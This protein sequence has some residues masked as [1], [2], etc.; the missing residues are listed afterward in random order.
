MLT[1]FPRSIRFVGREGVNQ[2]AVGLYGNPA[3]DAQTSLHGFSAG[4]C[5]RW[6]ETKVHDKGDLM[7]KTKDGFVDLKASVGK[8]YRVFPE[9]WWGHRKKAHVYFSE[10]GIP[11]EE[12]A[13][14][15]EIVGR[16]GSKIYPHGKDGTLA[17]EMNSRSHSSM[18]ASSPFLRKKTEFENGGVYLFPPERIHEVAAL[19]SARRKRQMSPEALLRSLEALGKARRMPPATLK[20]PFPE[21]RID[22]LS[23]S[24]P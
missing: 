17:V 18:S 21:P 22:F 23:G 1:A 14:Y 5:C 6:T 4:V 19:I 3:L 8:T 15:W 11:K 13:Y 10:Y 24:A 9:D 16:N 20:T 2:G 7:V 12:W